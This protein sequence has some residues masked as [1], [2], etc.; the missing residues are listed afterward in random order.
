VSAAHDFTGLSTGIDDEQPI[1]EA[2]QPGRLPDEWWQQT[3][4]L[5]HIALAADS[6]EIG[7]EAV[8]VAV[9]V[10][11]VAHIPPAIRLPG[12]PRDGAPN[13][14]VVL[15][16]PPGVGKG[17]AMDLA[18][19]LVPAPTGTRRTPAGTAEGF[20]KSFFDPNPDQA[21]RKLRPMV[22][23]R[24]PVIVRSDEV[25]S[26]IQQMARQSASGEGLIAQWK[27]MI[28]GEQLGFGYATP[29]KRVIVPS[30]SYRCGLIFGVVPAHAK[31]LF[32]D[33]G[34][35]LPQRMLFAPATVEHLPADDDI[36]PPDPAPM[37]WDSPWR[38]QPGTPSGV[39][40]VVPV[41]DDVLER[42]RREA[43]DLKRR[44]YA[45]EPGSDLE[46]HRV[47]NRLRT[48]TAIATLHE[49]RSVSMQWL[50]LAE[51]VTA[52]SDQTSLWLLDRARVTAHSEAKTANDKHAA[53]E[54]GAAE[55]VD[56]NREAR[57]LERIVKGARRMWELVK[58]DRAHT[59][60]EARRLMR[61]YEK[62]EIERCL[63]HAVD[64]DWLLEAAEPGQGSDKRTLSLGP[65]TP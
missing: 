61:R 49:A 51:D 36:P 63:G 16:G 55:A 6:R 25:G 17:A 53:R 5:A 10:Q 18:E 29:E 13:L 14:L 48:A 22:Q 50:D 27:K 24:S 32:D 11:V 9:L 31:V 26:L 54:V 60:G 38:P 19:Y 28:S 15:T 58:Q 30:L 57:Q 4:Q 20:V 59:V 43:L 12:P 46:T 35:G 44:V 64:L 8:L 47:Y 3:S 39:P 45:E 21:D 2:I 52:M 23:H 1:I 33:R 37:K 42:M 65:V 40:N 34:G 7:R 41:D 56:R 62:D